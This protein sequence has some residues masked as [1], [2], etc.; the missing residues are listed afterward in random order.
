MS[1]QDFPCLSEGFVL[2]KRGGRPP[3]H[4]RDLAVWMMHHKITEIDGGTS[5]QF[6]EIASAVFRIND[7]AELRKCIRK[8]KKIHDKSLMFSDGDYVYLVEIA[9]V[10]NGVPIPGSKAWIWAPGMREAHKMKILSSV[11][12]SPVN[13]FRHTAEWGGVKP[14]NTG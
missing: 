2:T 1:N 4:A 8:A 12:S 7:E 11:A 6:Y 3:K 5:A 9:K 10:M 13:H 14:F